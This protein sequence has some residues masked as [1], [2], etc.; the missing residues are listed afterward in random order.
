MGKLA[1]WVGYAT[2]ALARA[3]GDTSY[4]AK[5]MD[6]M[7]KIKLG[8]GYDL[9]SIGRVDDSKQPKA[10]GIRLQ[11]NAVQAYE[12]LKKTDTVDP[13]TV[14]KVFVPEILDALNT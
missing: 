7:A 10:V 13:K 4:I 5:E 2:L 9:N 1:C 11:D 8:P 12:A 6:S 3:S 14:S